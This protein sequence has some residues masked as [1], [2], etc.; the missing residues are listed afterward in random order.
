MGFGG[1][2]KVPDRLHTLMVKLHATRKVDG[3]VD[4][5]LWIHDINGYQQEHPIEQL[6]RTG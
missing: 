2:D 3:I 6:Y 4:E 1:G 5:V